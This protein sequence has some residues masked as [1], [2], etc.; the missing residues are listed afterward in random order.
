MCTAYIVE[1]PHTAGAGRCAN[2]IR[3]TEAQQ[4]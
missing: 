1:A 4:C 3:P 2:G